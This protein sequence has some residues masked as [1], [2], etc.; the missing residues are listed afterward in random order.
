MQKIFFIFILSLALFSCETESKF[1]I[2]GNITDAQGNMLY[3]EHVGVSKTSLIDSVKLKANGHFK[4]SKKRPDSPNFYRLKLNK[5][6]IDLAIDSTEIIK[7][8]TDSAFFAKNYTIEGS[9]NCLKIKELSILRNN[10]ANTDRK[11]VV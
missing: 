8:Q 7:I 6:F 1:T 10:T 2:E 11:S 4:F 5:Q 9:E 3:L